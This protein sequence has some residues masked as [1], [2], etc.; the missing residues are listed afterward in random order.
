MSL[1]PTQI[2]AILAA[3]AAGQQI[4]V[5]QILKVTWSDPSVIKYYA[6][7]ALNQTPPFLGSGFTIEPRIIF[8]DK[9]DPFFEFEINPDLTT[10]EIPI[11]FDDIDKAITALFQTYKS[12]VDCE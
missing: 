8:P 7:S 2:A 5:C 10:K 11:V 6:G 12:G 3:E 9:D 4:A 1:T